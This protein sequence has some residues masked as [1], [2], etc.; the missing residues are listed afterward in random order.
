[1]PGLEI[2]RK[3]LLERLPRIPREAKVLHIEQGYLR[4]HQGRLRRTIHPDGA[5][6]FEH[7]IKRGR[8]FVRE[9]DERSLSREEFEKLWPDTDGQ[10]LRK[11]RHLLRD[12]DGGVWAI[13]EFAD[14][15]L[16]L[17]EIELSSTETPFEFP[18]WLRPHI[19][20]EVTDDPDYTNHAIARRLGQRS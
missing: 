13:D 17:A 14:A 19:V 8:G 15:D 16:V 20:R 10:R 2:E 12:R 11:T 5:V 1:M 4:D 3:Y 9:E 7:T 6:T 18:D